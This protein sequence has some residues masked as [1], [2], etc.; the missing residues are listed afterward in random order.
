MIEYNWADDVLLLDIE[1]ALWC[2]DDRK[3]TK[4][5]L[6]VDGRPRFECKWYRYKDVRAHI[7]DM[8]PP[9]CHDE[10]GLFLN[11][12][13]LIRSETWDWC[14]SFKVEW[15][16]ECNSHIPAVLQT[17]DNWWGHR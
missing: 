7:G 6:F 10:L 1:G 5:V 4:V 8:V 2:A 12:R 14:E 17:V 15:G 3:S 13:D 9:E 16:K 11:L